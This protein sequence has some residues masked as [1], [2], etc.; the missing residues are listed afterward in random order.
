[1][2]FRSGEW[3]TN[4]PKELESLRQRA[5]TLHVAT[6]TQE[7]IYSIP[8]ESRDEFEKYWPA[9]LQVRTPD[10]PLTLS[11]VSGTDTEHLSSAKPCVR[12]KG[13]SGAYV[14]GNSKIGG[15]I[16]VKELDAGTMLFAGAPWPK[17]LAGP[18][19]EL[20]EYEIGRAHV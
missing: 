15:K 14:G 4:W 5:K 13:P 10:S 3:P 18:K 9:L 12:I 17:E 19:G 7:N 20:P 1:M 8:F 6:G 11:K 2:L 16:D